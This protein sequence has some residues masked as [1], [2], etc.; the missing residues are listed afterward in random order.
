[1]SIN[2]L[3]TI[4]STLSARVLVRKITRFALYYIINKLKS[5]L[6]ND[7]SLNIGSKKRIKITISSFPFASEP[8]EH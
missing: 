8:K 6:E 7:E 1:M 4:T 5:N 3:E 2:I